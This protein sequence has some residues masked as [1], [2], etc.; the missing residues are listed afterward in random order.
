[1]KAILAASYGSSVASALANSIVPLETAFAAAYPDYI[2][3][4]AFTGKRIRETLAKAGTPVDSPAEALER[5]A[6]EGGEE[7]ILQPS[8][9]ISG[10]EYDLLCEEAAAFEG[11][12]KTLKVGAP[13]LHDRSDLETVCRLMH[14]EFGRDG[15]LTVI[16]GHGSEHHANKL[17]SD[18]ADVCR[19][20]GYNNM[21]IA[22]LEGTPVLED[23]LP[24][25][26]ASGCKSVTLTPLLFVAGGHAA[27]DMAG[28]EPDSWKSRLESEG[29]QVNAVVKGLGEYEAIR[30]L[31][32][33]HLAD[34]IAE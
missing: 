26:R 7:V 8:H 22:T 4:R 15:S 18:F 2:V 27:K 16:M 12:F 28:D 13:L 3:R 25:L 20:L 10:S 24:A 6:A 23:I 30:A 5:L 1:M 34:A 9:I 33:S 19:E 31:Y 21:F 11:R 14:D 32:V 17:Y 29:F